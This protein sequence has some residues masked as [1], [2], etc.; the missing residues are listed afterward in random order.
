MN[1]GIIAPCKNECKNRDRFKAGKNMV[2]RLR[3]RPATT[4][5]PETSPS[6]ALFHAPL[7][8]LHEPLNLALPLFPATVVF[9]CHG[10]PAPFVARSI[11]FRSIQPSG[12]LVRRLTS[13]YNPSQVFKPYPNDA[14]FQDANALQIPKQRQSEAT[15]A[16]GVGN[17]C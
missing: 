17:C 5:P 12:F 10:L 16:C 11:L 9:R 3:S 14:G 8:L 1:A 13:A 15:L 7:P 4:P 2:M 6:Q